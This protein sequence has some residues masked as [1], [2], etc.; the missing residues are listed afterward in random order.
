LV[1]QRFFIVI[2]H[3]PDAL[4]KWG[5]SCNDGL[6]DQVKSYESGVRN[7]GKPTYAISD[8]YECLLVAFSD[9]GVARPGNHLSASLSRGWMLG[10]ERSPN[11]T[12][13]TVSPNCVM[14][15][16][17]FAAIKVIQY[18]PTWVL[19]AQTVGQWFR[20]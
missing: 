8:R 20:G 2:S 19:S 11:G 13:A 5:E 4:R 7:N 9:H 6:T 3:F 14:F 12:L 10:K 17:L 16:L 15:A 18:D 1:C